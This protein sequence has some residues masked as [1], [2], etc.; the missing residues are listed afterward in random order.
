M[1]ATRLYTGADG[2]SHFEDIELPT[3]PDDP[4]LKNFRPN[5]DIM[6]RDPEA[7]MIGGP[8]SGAPM[9]YHNAPHRL[10]YIMIGGELEIGVADGSSRVFKPGDIF[11]AED[12]TGHGHT[13]KAT[14]RASILVHLE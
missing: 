1:K 3:K 12:T 6:F 11:I 2:E 4:N 5:G 9:P 14:N 7:S 8:Q 13:S 10:M